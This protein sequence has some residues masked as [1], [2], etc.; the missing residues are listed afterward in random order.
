MSRTE[1]GATLQDVDSDRVD[2]AVCVRLVQRGLCPSLHV[3]PVGPNSLFEI[4]LGL[5]GHAGQ[6]GCIL[7]PYS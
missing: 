3:S 7:Y 5:L 2:D 4:V 6:R 1:S